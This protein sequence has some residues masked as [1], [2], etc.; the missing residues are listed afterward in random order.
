[1]IEWI[2]QGPGR[3]IADSYPLIIEKIGSNT[4][5]LSE[6]VE[7]IPTFFVTEEKTLSACKQ[8]ADEYMMYT[9]GD[10]EAFRKSAIL[11]SILAENRTYCAVKMGVI[12]EQKRTMAIQCS[13]GGK[14]FSIGP[15]GTFTT[16]DHAAN[17][18]LKILYT[19]DIHDIQ[20][21]AE[22]NSY[23]LGLLGLDLLEYAILLYYSDDP[24]ADKDA[25][26]DRIASNPVKVS[27]DFYD[28]MTLSQLQLR[29]CFT[30]KDLDKIEIEVCC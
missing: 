27:L 2:K 29:I 23:L 12:P 22:S 28:A 3:Y 25:I 8:A 11:Q 17:M 21:M 10:Y 14:D 19:E 15:F 16:S 6:R 7:D 9:E 5:R 26:A 1:M 4:W 18:A 20:A 24:T 30:S 13:V